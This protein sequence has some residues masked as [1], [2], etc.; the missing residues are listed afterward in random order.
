MKNVKLLPCNRVG[1]FLDSEN[2]IYEEKCI[3]IALFENKSFD[4]G[5]LGL[6]V[7]TEE[8]LIE[9]GVNLEEC[10]N[11]QYFKND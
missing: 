2:K 4:E 10:N 3:A 8:D 9:G 5:S 1:V 7:I 6:R 11:F